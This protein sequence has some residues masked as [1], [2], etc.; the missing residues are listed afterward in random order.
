MAKARSGAGGATGL[1]K[2]RAHRGSKVAAAIRA[3]ARLPA[4]SFY[5][6]GR[7][8][9][10]LLDRREPIGAVNIKDLCSKV[11]LGMSHM[12]ANK[13]LQ[14]SRSFPRSVALKQG[15]EKCYALV[16][17]ARTIERPG[18][19]GKVLARDEAI[20][21]SRGL[22]ASSATAPEIFA[23]IR[24]LK[25][26]GRDSRV[27]PEERARGERAARATERLFRRLGVRR[28]VAHVVY[29]SGET[30]IALFVPLD[31]AESLAAAGPRAPPGGKPRPRAAPRTARRSPA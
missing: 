14:I 28:A 18:E 2:D 29:R 31:V 8:L 23:A 16:V 5:D 25:Q 30:Q 21:A 13:Y 26:A 19:A 4:K 9:S 12:T 22:R 6:T 3:H 15:I 20:R 7:F 1:R 17:Y 27:P 11:P 24:A 10:E